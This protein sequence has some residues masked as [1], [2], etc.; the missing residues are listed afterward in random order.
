[1]DVC[2]LYDLGFEGRNWTFEKKVAGGSYCP[3]RLDRALATADWC[4][5]FLMPRVTHLT[6]AASDHYPIML[7]WQQVSG[8]KGR[9]KKKMFRYEM[10]W[11]AHDQFFPMLVRT[12]LDVGEARTVKELQE[13]LASVSGS[14]SEWSVNSFGNVRR[15]LKNL[16]AELEKLRADPCV[17]AHRMQKSRYKRG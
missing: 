7:R 11:E 12:W 2:G 13:K 5:R 8:R 15:E 17:L 4:T 9:K 6:A 16:Y 1:M 3:V 10:M 14:L